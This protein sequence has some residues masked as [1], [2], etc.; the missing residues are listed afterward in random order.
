MLI[1][2]PIDECLVGMLRLTVVGDCEFDR[3]GPGSFRHLDGYV[4][5]QKMFSDGTGRN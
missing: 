2:Y 4:L 5:Q 1:H 3:R